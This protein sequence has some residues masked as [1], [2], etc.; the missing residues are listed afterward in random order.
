MAT[1]RFI[2]TWLH[3]TVTIA[4]Y[5][6]CLFVA[7]TF[8]GYAIVDGGGIGI[9]FFLGCYQLGVAAVATYA[10]YKWKIPRPY[11]LLKR[12]W[13]FVL[14]WIVAAAALG[15]AINAT[16]YIETSSLIKPYGIAII[17]ILP[18]LIAS[19]FVYVTYRIYSDFK[20]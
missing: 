10:Y 17:I 2:P 5:V 8:I 1:N 11:R 18:M 9:Q 13:A 14:V 6:N 15:I 3:R 19:Y 12:Y 16:D 4:H 7:A 20:K